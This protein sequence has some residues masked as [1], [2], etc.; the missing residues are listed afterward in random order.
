MPPFETLSVLPVAKYIRSAWFHA[1]NLPNPT[2]LVTV[3][4]THRTAPQA[5]SQNPSF[6]GASRR[7][8][9]ATAAFQQLLAG[10]AKSGDGFRAELWFRRLP[11]WAG[12]FRIVCT[13]RR[14]FPNLRS[15]E[16]SANYCMS[17]GPKL[18]QAQSLKPTLLQELEILQTCVLTPSDSP[19]RTPRPTFC[20]SKLAGWF[21]ASARRTPP[22]TLLSLQPLLAQAA[23]IFRAL[24]LAPGRCC[25]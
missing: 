5:T 23:S 24:R 1:R 19:P 8:H 22:A 16:A 14:R 11:F 18:P 7:L 25:S 2:R 13:G 6:C 10:E 12:R 21:G 15:T 9:P 17:S 20:K 3:R 4:N